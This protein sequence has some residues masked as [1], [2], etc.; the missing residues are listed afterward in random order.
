MSDI[1]PKAILILRKMQTVFNVIIC[2][3]ENENVLKND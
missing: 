1:F 3:R 2:I